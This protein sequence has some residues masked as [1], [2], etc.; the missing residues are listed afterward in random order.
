[1]RRKKLTVENLE[2]A[3]EIYFACAFNSG[4]GSRYVLSPKDL[5]RNLMRQIDEGVGT[6]GDRLGS[7]SG[8]AK[9]II[10][11][12]E[13]FFGRKYAFRYVPNVPY[14]DEETIQR[15][16]QIKREMN[17]AWKKNGF[18]VFKERRW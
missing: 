13:G 3:V 5:A 2:E 16:E 4:E 7:S 6:I 12:S 17:E 1:M 8:G 9:F 14:A 15:Q 11:L 10:E 18:P